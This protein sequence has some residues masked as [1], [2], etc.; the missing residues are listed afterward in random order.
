MFSGNDSSS[1]TARS[2]LVGVDDTK[3]Y[4]FEGFSVELEFDTAPTNGQT[5]ISTAV[6]GTVVT[7]TFV[8][9]VPVSDDDGDVEI[10]TT[11]VSRNNCKA[12]MNLEAGA[13]TLYGTGTTAHPDASA[14]VSHLADAI[15]LVS[16]SP[17]T[18]SGTAISSGNLL[19]RQIDMITAT[20][21]MLQYASGDWT[22]TA[23]KSAAI[24]IVGCTVTG[25]TMWGGGAGTTSG[26][27][28]TYNHAGVSQ[29]YVHIQRNGGGSGQTRPL[30]LPTGAGVAASITDAASAGAY[31]HW[32]GGRDTTNI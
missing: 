2:F 16:A 6:D 1:R 12:A 24:N 3:T 11:T 14:N 30:N 31:V 23:A 5:L 13:G 20:T 26:S 19:L 25:V 7:Y 21:T 4:P 8:T 27:M 9:D 17:L 15:H 22:H 28:Y 32:V 18:W 29:Q 10:G